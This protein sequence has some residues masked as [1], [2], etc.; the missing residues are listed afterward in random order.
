MVEEGKLD[1]R[2]AIP[3][4]LSPS[5][6]SPLPKILDPV[7]AWGHILANNPLGSPHLEE[8][9]DEDSGQERHGSKASRAGVGEEDGEGDCGERGKGEGSCLLGFGREVTGGP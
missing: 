2:L 8:P 1:K 5:Q 7:L 4:Q 9:S 6:A 3:A